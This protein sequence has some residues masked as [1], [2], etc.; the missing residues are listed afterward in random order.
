MGL[1][2]NLY[3]RD[4]IPGNAKLTDKKPEPTEIAYWK[5]HNALHN[6]M[7]EL[8]VN[9]TNN[10]KEDFNCIELILTKK[11]LI[12]L[13]NDI[14]KNNLQPTEGFFFGNTEYKPLQYADG[15][16]AAIGKALYQI[17]LGQEIFYDSSW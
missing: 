10:S 4:K 7:T 5:K 12:N 9:K 11:D 13:G 14:M 17:N 2:M 1:D 3:Y 15:D 8:Y 6:W 16:L